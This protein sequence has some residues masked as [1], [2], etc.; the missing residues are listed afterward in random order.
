MIRQLVYYGRLL[1][2]WLNGNHAYAD[3]LR[4]HRLVHPNR[5]P[6]DRKAHYRYIQQER[7]S[8]INRCC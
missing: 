7:W 3:Y 6:M 5:R 1:I 8:K 2:H 4:H